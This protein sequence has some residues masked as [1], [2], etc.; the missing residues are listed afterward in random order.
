MK[1]IALILLILILNA[2]QSQKVFENYELSYSKSGGYAPVYE[3]LL[4]KNN[5]ATYFFEGHGKKYSEKISLSDTEMKLLYEAIE[6]NNLRQI[7]EDHKK[8]Y[9]YITTTIK[10]KKDNIIKNDGSGIFP[11]DQQRWNNVVN[12]FEELITS[13]K[14]RK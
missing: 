8:M 4:I 10:I 3:N 2:C 12:A 1:N 7:R 5:T 6:Q 13:R 11:Q 9:D 14:L